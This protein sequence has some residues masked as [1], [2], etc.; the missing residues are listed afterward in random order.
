MKFRYISGIT[1][2][3]FWTALFVG[4]YCKASYRDFN[5][6]DIPLEHFVVG[7]ITDEFLDGQ[8]NEMEEYLE[9]SPMIIAVQCQEKF[10][11]RFSC[12]TQKVIVNHV[13]K[14][15]NLKE[16]DCIEIARDGSAIFADEE[17]LIN[18]KPS[19]NM[20]FVNEMIPEKEYLV[21]LD[22]KLETYDESNIY[23]QGSEFVLAPIFCYEKTQSIACES[24]DEDGAF[25]NYEDVEENE[26]FIM[27]DNAAVKLQDFK[28]RLFQK[29]NY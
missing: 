16:G 4:V 23:V 22:H 13:F 18:G 3:F 2:L 24:I 8:L 15:E 11:Y 29:Y 21:Y 10:T 28:E 17:S 25:A 6:E 7:L 26:F 12:V 5:S 20:G 19:I 27:S 9:S 1:V 14:G